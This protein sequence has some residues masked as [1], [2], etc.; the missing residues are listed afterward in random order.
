MMIT[1][2][3]NNTVNSNLT[4]VQYQTNEPLSGSSFYWALFFSVLGTLMLDF[5]ADNCQTPSRA[6]L[7][8]VCLSEEHGKALS[9]F[10]IMAGIGGCLGYALGA[11][12][13]N[14]TIFANLIGDNIKTGE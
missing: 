11:V 10:T 13:W 3:T 1:I 4:N 8:D 6:Y 7:L 9:T 5:S 2:I 14:G 12:D